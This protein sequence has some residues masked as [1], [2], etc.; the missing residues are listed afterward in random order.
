MKEEVTKNPTAV[1]IAGLLLLASACFYVGTRWAN[2]YDQVVIVGNKG[3][4]RV[5]RSPAVALVPNATRIHDLSAFNITISPPP[6]LLRPPPPPAFAPPAQL[7]VLDHDGA[8]QTDF[9]VGNED[10][11][12]DVDVDGPE[13]E[14]G[15]GTSDPGVGNSDPGLKG[16]DFTN[17]KRFGLCDAN[18][19]EYIPCLD[20][21]DAIKRLSSTERGERFERLCPGEVGRLRC[22]VPT[23][24]KYK[25]PIPWPRSRDEVWYGNVPHTKLV[26]DKGGQ[27]WI[28][29]RKD[30]FIFPGGGTQFIHGADHYIDQM[31][32][33]VP[34]LAFGVHTRVALDVGCGV[35]SFGAFLLS[36]NVLTLS[37]A[38]KDVHENQIQFALE[39][40]VPAMVAAFATHR[41]L[42]PSQAFDLIHCSRCRINWTRDGGILLL[43]VDRML[44]GGGYFAWAAQPVYKHEANLQEA[45]K[46]MEDLATRLC[47]KLVNKE[48]Y[49]AI[50]QKPLN[51]TCY[52]SR[53]EGV[54]PPLCDANDD[55]DDVWYV[56]LKACIT[57]LPEN[58]FGRNL[59][60]WPER[61][62]IPPDRLEFAA[63]DAYSAKKELF[64][65]EQNYNRF[66]VE[67][68]LRGLG[69]KRQHFRN[70]MDM[71]AG[72]GGFATA[73]TDLHVDCWVMN[74]VPISGPNTLPVIYDRGLI[75]VVH[76]WCEPFDTYPRTYDLLHASG[77]FSI[78]EKR[79]NIADILLEMDRIMRPG[80]HAYIRD[81]RA[82]IAKIEVVAKAIGWRTHTFDTEEGPYA[83]R[84]VLGCEKM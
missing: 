24:Q 39:R 17:V 78:E 23:P 67:A 69:W 5:P 79:C 54:Q 25:T 44:R 8:M 68:Y 22:R 14:F 43:E 72:F 28:E 38:P 34:E 4:A 10:D 12:N 50:W 29:L 48:G 36:R 80:A 74:V 27:N 19:S 57:W 83:S 18:M 45:W 13:V 32:Q 77:L 62:H 84:K 11:G 66:L 71:R 42:Y 61:V 73:L 70:V 82:V 7:G 65:A 9:R 60:K 31:A 15:N 20:N 33:M 21:L 1:K 40:G 75:G 81:T 51:N 52:V 76:D 58:G 2:T 59:S 41:L 55:P 64:I 49:I 16:R 46:E 63:V 37:I 3:S 53:D 30:K 47:W 56:P 35:A 26:E 6:A